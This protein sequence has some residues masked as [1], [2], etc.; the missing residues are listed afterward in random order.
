MARRN[1]LLLVV[2]I[3]KWLLAV[4]HTV[5][6]QT[7]ETVVWLEFGEVTTP[8]MSERTVHRLGADTD[9]VKQKTIKGGDAI[10]VMLGGGRLGGRS[11]GEAA[12]VYL[13]M[14]RAR[15]PMAQGGHALASHSPLARLF[16]EA[17]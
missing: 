8:V 7:M 13:S 11:D 5:G 16:D 6:V 1:S 9:R 12:Y 4:C 14:R 3:L 15:C 17:D 10:R 2:V